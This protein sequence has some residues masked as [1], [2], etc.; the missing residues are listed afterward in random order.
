MRAWSNDGSIQE[1]HNMLLS[2]FLRCKLIYYQAS[3][4]EQQGLDRSGTRAFNFFSLVLD[5]GISSSF[6]TIDLAT[7][8]DAGNTSGEELDLADANLWRGCVFKCTVALQ[9]MLQGL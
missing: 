8:E 5:S 6:L 7:A 4:S 3:I 1:K 2:T 9:R